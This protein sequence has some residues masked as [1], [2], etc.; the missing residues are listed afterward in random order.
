M[1][2]RPID[3]RTAAEKAFKTV[4][5]KPAPELPPKPQAVPGVKG[6]YGIRSRGPSDLRYAEVTIAV[7]RNANVE[8]AHAIADEVEERLKR[9]LQ[10]H[11]VTVHVEPC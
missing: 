6:A 10:F 9:D 1:S 3:S 4:T 8:S 5:T 2:R 7:D 11:E